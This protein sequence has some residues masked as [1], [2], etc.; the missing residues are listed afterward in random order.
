MGICFSKEKLP[1][2]Y[3]IDPNII[4][5]IQY[6]GWCVLF[7]YYDGDTCDIAYTIN[8][9]AHRERCRLYGYDSAEMRPKHADFPDEKARQLEKEQAQRDRDELIKLTNGKLLWCKSH[10]KGKYGRSLYDIWIMDDLDSVKTDE[11]LLRNI[12][13]KTGHGKKYFG[14]K[15]T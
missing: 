3:S 1:K 7:N 12:M 15:K 13:I 11:N 5:K 8:G 10:G 4:E 2:I 9:I 14:G 6:E